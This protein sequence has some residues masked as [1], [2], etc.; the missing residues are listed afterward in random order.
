MLSVFFKSAIVLL[1]IFPNFVLAQVFGNF[2]TAL[3]A[4]FLGDKTAQREGF[5]TFNPAKHLDLK[6][7]L[8]FLSVILFANMLLGDSPVTSL[9]FVF[10][11]VA[12]IRRPVIVPVNEENF[13]NPILGECATILA[14]PLGSIFYSFLCL[15]C[16]RFLP[17]DLPAL[18]WQFFDAGATIGIQ[19][20]VL[21]LIPLPPQAG[22]RI[23][24]LLIP[25]EQEDFLEAY[26]TYGMFIF[27]G[28]LIIPGVN[29][30]MFGVIRNIT[31]GIKMMFFKLLF[32]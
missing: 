31:T 9:V 8:I 4:Y 3:T 26:S 17:I 1:V 19:L 10:L 6:G 14:D 2:L 25:E 27:L 23:M 30:V 15:A 18:V 29:D 21:D 22:G 24:Q 28:L 11:L 32:R 5:L 16:I 7:S 12:N 13:K 20:G